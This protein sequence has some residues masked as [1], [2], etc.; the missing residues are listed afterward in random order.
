MAKGGQTP[1]EPSSPAMRAAWKLKE[2]GDVVGARHEARR[3]LVDTPSPEDRAQAE[4]LLARSATPPVLYGYAAIAALILLVLVALAS[5][6][7]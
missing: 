1:K 6:R 2:A 7:Y 5:T 4:E 3:L